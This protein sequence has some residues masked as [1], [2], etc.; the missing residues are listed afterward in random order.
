MS[1]SLIFIALFAIFLSAA[2]HLKDKAELQVAIGQIN[3]YAEAIDNFKDKYNFYPGDF[4]FAAK[5]GPEQNSGNG[6]HLVS[7]QD[8][9]L[10]AWLHLDVTEF[11]FYDFNYNRQLQHAKITA[12][13]PELAKG[14]C[15][16]QILADSKLNNV[17]FHFPKKQNFLRIAA[18][19]NFG[20]LSWSC[21]SGFEAKLYDQK[22]DDGKPLTGNLYAD[23]GHELSWQEDNK[24]CICPVGNFAE[25]CLA[26]KKETCIMQLAL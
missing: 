15:G 21:L 25:Y 3:I 14:K 24:L 20:N 23:Q 16:L 22:I 19:K 26:L 5:I 10:N 11:I 2:N 13:M 17:N 1:I 6:D 7:D 4:P 9:T 12:N 8:E 18:D